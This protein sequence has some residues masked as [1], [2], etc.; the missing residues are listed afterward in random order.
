MRCELP[1]NTD[2]ERWTQ[3]KNISMVISYKSSLIL[4]KTT[5]GV[6]FIKNGYEN[7]LS[8]INFKNALNRY[9]YQTHRILHVLHASH[10]WFIYLSD[11]DQDPGPKLHRLDSV[12][13]GTSSRDPVDETD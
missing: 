10:G 9:M 5:T 3:D 1:L 11:T 6:T 4:I 7:F 2:G 8:Q 12:D 13:D